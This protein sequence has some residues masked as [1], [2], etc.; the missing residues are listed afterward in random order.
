MRSKSW[1][2]RRAL[3]VG[4]CMA[5]ERVRPPQ[6]RA[7]TDVP[8]NGIDLTEEW[9]T[10]VLCAGHPD[11]RVASFHSPGGH[12]GT[13]T[14]AALRVRYNP[15]GTEVGL[16][17]ELY[18]KTTASYSQRLLLGGA[19][20]LS[21]ETHFFMTFRPRV[22]MEAPRGYWGGVDERSWRS[23]ILMEDIAATKGA[24]FIEPTT[25]LTRAQV[26][27]MLGNM[28]A[29]HGAWWSDPSLGVLKTAHDHFRNVSSFIDMGGRCAVG[30]ERAK[31]M[32]P[33]RLYGQAARMWRGTERGLEMATTQLPRTLLHG[34][35][36]VGQTYITA[37]GRM[38]LTDWQATLQGGWAY[39]FAY[40][41][42]S[43][44]EPEDRR[45]WERELLEVYLGKLADA[46]APAPGFDDAWLAYR[47]QLF[48]PYSA[49]AFTIGR[50]FY[51]PRMQ[52]EDICLAII[53]RLATA[54]DDLDSFGALGI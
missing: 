47:Q 7:R 45:L 19:D 20:V 3:V 29:Y 26:E 41:V 11:A 16:P 1:L 49:W 48:Y 17:T 46:G 31:S 4:G 39:D 37:E 18:T 43:A 54:I 32:I 38:G 22:A 15:A 14:R 36:H 6:P 53:H 50:A 44:C 28:A 13:S 35:S 51:Q 23:M 8:R 2:A 12:S 33:A 27:D 42:G 5:A 34:D 10:A 52:P 21:G 30:M 9:L 40:F 24:R 25:P